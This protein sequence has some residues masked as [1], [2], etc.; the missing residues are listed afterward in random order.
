MPELPEVE[1]IRRYLAGNIVGKTVG[2]VESLLPRMWRN[3]SLVQRAGK[4][5]SPALQAFVDACSAS[6]QPLMD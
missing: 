2:T 1:I 4:R 3:F 5:R 6:V